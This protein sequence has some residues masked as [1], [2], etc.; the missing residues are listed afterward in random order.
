M[1][2]LVSGLAGGAIHALSGPDHL[3][4]VTPLS[5]GDRWKGARAGLEWG[6]GHGAGV[7]VLGLL[8]MVAH[9]AVPIELLSGWSEF[10]VGFVLVGVGAWA[11][12]RGVRAIRHDT[13]HSL[14]RLHHHSSATVGLGALH[15]SAG[16]GHLVAVL[17]AAGLSSTGAVAYLVSYVL[18]AALAMAL[19]GALAGELSARGGRKVLPILLTVAG[20]VAIVVGLAWIVGGLAA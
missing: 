19:V 9:R 5:L 17:P 20:G 14:G 1:L 18:G 6:V 4:A 10:L 12:F 8:A 15:G 7:G 11:A 13:A 16:A 2:T 3:A